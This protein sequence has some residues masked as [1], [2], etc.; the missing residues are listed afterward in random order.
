[1]LDR[2]F[3][4]IHILIFDCLTFMLQDLKIVAPVAKR[5]SPEGSVPLQADGADRGRAFSGQHDTIGCLGPPILFFGVFFFFGYSFVCAACSF[6][7]YAM[8]FRCNSKK[9]RTIL[10]WDRQGSII[11][12][13]ARK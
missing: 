5:M 7:Y 9:R 8:V 12:K 10:V 1:M 2:Q 3:L 6:I 13:F 4:I 11:V